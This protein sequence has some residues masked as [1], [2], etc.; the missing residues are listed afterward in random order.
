MWHLH[1]LIGIAVACLIYVLGKKGHL[2]EYMYISYNFSKISLKE[3]ED[4]SNRRYGSIYY[5]S[6]DN[7]IWAYIQLGLCALLWPIVLNI[8]IIVKIFGL[9]I[10]EKKQKS[11]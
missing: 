9:F 8:L 4:F 5:M 2:S 7:T 6:S 11:F 3:K 10:K 1:F